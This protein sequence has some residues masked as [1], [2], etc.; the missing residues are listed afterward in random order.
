MADLRHRRRLSRRGFSG[1][2]PASLTRAAGGAGPAAESFRSGEP[3]PLV[4]GRQPLQ[5]TLLPLL[6]PRSRSAVG[7]GQERPEDLE[8]SGRSVCGLRARDPATDRRDD[9]RRSHRPP[10]VCGDPGRLR[11][12]SRRRLRVRE[13]DTLS[14]RARRRIRGGDHRRA[15]VPLAGPR[16][17]FR[18]RLEGRI[19]TCVESLRGGGWDRVGARAGLSDN[20]RTGS[21]GAGARDGIRRGEARPRAMEPVRCFGSACL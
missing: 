20:A 3:Q 7:R 13:P 17:R 18:R 8:T 4:L 12:A 19:P 9:P 10:G 21:A 16:V 5:R 14:A 2:A 6:G 11:R 1:R 15:R